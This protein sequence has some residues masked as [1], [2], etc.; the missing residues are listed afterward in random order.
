[1]TENQSST[2]Y[3]LYSDQFRVI[4]C[5]EFLHSEIDYTDLCLQASYLDSVPS[6]RF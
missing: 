2:M 5:L 6:E 1:V 3:V 4:N